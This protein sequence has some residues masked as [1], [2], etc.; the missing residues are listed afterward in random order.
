MIMENE[1]LKLEK[2]KIAVEQ[3]K[4]ESELLWQ[5]MNVYMLSNSVFIGLI[6]N[7]LN[8]DIIS[9]EWRPTY[10]IFGGL[11]VLIAVAWL[12]AFL[13]CNKYY[14]FRMAQAKELEPEDMKLLNDR[15]ERFSNRES[16]YIGGNSKPFRLEWLADKLKNKLAAQIMIIAFFVVYI[17]LIIISFPL[18]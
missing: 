6:A 13:R 16:V 9:D 10:L 12:G 1:Q 3:V 5:I 14:H 7:S 17:G 18:G 4:Y 8:S 2:Y 15:G 11:G